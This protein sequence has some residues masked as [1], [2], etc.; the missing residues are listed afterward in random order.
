MSNPQAIAQ[1]RTVKGASP[2]RVIGTTKN[3][4]TSTVPA[5]C[6]DVCG[7]YRQFSW[8]IAKQEGFFRPGTIP[9]RNHNPGDLK[10]VAGYSFPGQRGVDRFGHVIFK[11]DYWGW[12]ALQNQVRKMC[13]ESGRYS[14]QMSIQQIGRLYARDWKRWSANVAKN[15]NCDPHTTLAELFSIPPTV[16]VQPDSS[17]ITAILNIQMVMP[18]SASVELWHELY[19]LD[20]NDTRRV[21][22]VL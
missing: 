6:A 16:K 7:Q 1:T 5:E 2:T 15:M 17:K 13:V 8:A 19:E 12:A 10:F 21:Q 18:N 3:R 4:A 14:P 9:N 20:Q 22:Y 11:N